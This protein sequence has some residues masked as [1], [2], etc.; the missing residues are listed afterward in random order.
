MGKKFNQRQKTLHIAIEVMDRFFLDK[1]SQ[2]L[3][4]IQDMSSR[5]VNIVMVTCFLI[6]SKYDEI[7]D[8][9]VF[10]NDVQKYHYKQGLSN[11]PTWT[12]VVETER[13]LMNFFGWDLGFVLPIHFVEMFIA[14]GVLFEN[15]QDV[16]LNKQT[17][18]EISDK[19]YQILKEMIK[20]NH[21]FKNQGFSGNQV[22]A[23]VVYLARQEVLG[24]RKAKQVWPK[25]LQLISRQTDRE[26]KKLA[27]I[28]RKQNSQRTEPFQDES[29][30]DENPAY[31]K[32]QVIVDLT[33]SRQ[34][35]QSSGLEDPTLMSPKANISIEH[36]GSAKKQTAEKV[37]VAQISVPILKKNATSG[38]RPQQLS[39]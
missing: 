7:D 1:R 31:D 26:V 3:S 15:E 23:V 10:I 35:V 19:C 25:E 16:D 14:N 22:A 9:L 6:A 12:E 17:A 4:D 24:M 27:G 13:M 32:V 36:Y 20:Q 39:S 29:I 21:C 2:S 37:P 18:Q 34:A 30:P 33:K 38:G 8:Q 11:S 5:I 28:Y